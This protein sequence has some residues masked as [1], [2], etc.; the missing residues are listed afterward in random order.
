MNNTL[1]RIPAF[2]PA[3]EFVS[4]FGFWNSGLR[5]LMLM[6]PLL[7]ALAASAQDAPKRG[8]RARLGLDDSELPPDAHHLKISDPAP[9]FSLRGVDGK[10]YTLDN[11][12]KAPVLM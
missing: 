5:A 12:K 4:D 6:L 1:A 10:T 7:S 3:L 11:F 8:G 2:M 9:N